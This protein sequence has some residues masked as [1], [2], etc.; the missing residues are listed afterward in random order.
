MC[1]GGPNRGT[2]LAPDLTVFPLIPYFLL[3]G[4]CFYK[5]GLS[6]RPGRRSCTTEKNGVGAKWLDEGLYFG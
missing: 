3:A 6:E 2:F 1:G 4:M 5:Q